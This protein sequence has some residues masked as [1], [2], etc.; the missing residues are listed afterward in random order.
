MATEDESE[1]GDLPPPL[2]TRGMQLWPFG[3]YRERRAE[4]AIHWDASRGCWDAFGYD[5]V[6]SVLTDHATFSSDIQRGDRDAGVFGDSMLFS[7]PP[8]HTDLRDPVEEYFT[9]GAVASLE[10]EIRETAGSLLDNALDGE[11]GTVDV[12]EAI[13][14]PLP[15]TTI[16][17]LI[18]VPTEDRA[19]FKEWSDR[20]VNAPQMSGGDPERAAAR[21]ER[22]RDDLVSY[23]LEMLEDRRDDPRD[24]LLSGL[25]HETNLDDYELLT[26]TAL[27]LVAGNVTT[28][29]LVT[30][31]VRCFLKHDCVDA[32]TRDETALSRA[33]E[34]VL[35]YRSPV[36]RTARVATEA[37]TVAGRDVD[38]GEPVIC[39]I[40]SANRD[41]SRV[42]RPRAFLP[43]RSPNP[44]VA[45]GRGIHVCL[46]APLARLE[47]RVALDVMFDR[48]Q[49]V[50]P[51]ETE[52]EP[53]PSSFL[54]GVRSFPVTYRA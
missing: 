40:G 15:I 22:A 52:H 7:D 41:E 35:R 24:D 10:T 1:P 34:E 36:Q 6:V 21:N 4:G 16:A 37:A 51:V 9:P 48:M 32:V 45:F 5:A 47:A 2:R 44:H 50:T 39:W 11:A 14:Y 18:G 29:N 23:F 46:G 33:I 27:L 38:T 26:T 20:V 54:H 28:T 25:V 53:I 8:R 49:E 43:E 12:V 17:A 31:A 42:D 30:N 13:A 3:W 19:Q